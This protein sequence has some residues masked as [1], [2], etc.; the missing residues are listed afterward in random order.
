MQRCESD[1]VNTPRIGGHVEL[2]VRRPYPIGRIGDYP[3]WRGGDAVPFAA[4]PL[5]QPQP[6]LT[7][8]PLNPLVIDDPALCAGIVVGGPESPPGMVVSF[9]EK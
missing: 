2:E 5:R 9:V 3:R 1:C 7:P 8:K 4:P 6:F